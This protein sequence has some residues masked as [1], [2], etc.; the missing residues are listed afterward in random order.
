LESLRGR[1]NSEDLDIDGDNIKMAV[2]KRGME[3]VDMTH[4][5]QDRDRCRV[6]MNTVMNL[7]IPYEAGNFLTSWANY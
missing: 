3:G 1:E 2:R 7:W 4:L 5:T 6:L